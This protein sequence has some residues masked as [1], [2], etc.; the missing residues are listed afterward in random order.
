M[1]VYKN[2]N[3][4]EISFDD[5]DFGRAAAS[6]PLESEFDLIGGLLHCYSE[7]SLFQGDL[8]QFADRHRDGIE[9]IRRRDPRD[10]TIPEIAPWPPLAEWGEYSEP[11]STY[12][13]DFKRFARRWGLDRIPAD[14]GLEQLNFYCFLRA[15]R[16][17]G[18]EMFN[19]DYG[20]SFTVPEVPTPVVEIR[21]TDLWRADHESESEARKRIL[22]A[23]R[24]QIKAQFS[25]IRDDY[26]RAG[27]TFSYQHDLETSRQRLN[28]LY[29]RLAH[30]EPLASVSAEAQLAGANVSEKTVR[31]E[32]A[33]LAKLIGLRLP[34]PKR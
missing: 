8:V 30:R 4:F 22:T 5:E 15:L 12:L 17:F 14:K 29:R 28:W 16:R 9:E 19:A 21:I 23:C 11:A 13:C 2:D 32:T 26:R 10:Q 6:P 31:N 25:R 1:P 3:G 20:Y 7:D 18:P 27:F 33:K 24:D 34:P